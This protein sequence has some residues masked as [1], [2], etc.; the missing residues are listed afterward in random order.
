[1][2]VGGLMAGVSFR[3]LI[4]QGMEYDKH[5]TLAGIATGAVLMMFSLWVVD[6]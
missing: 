4:P 5:Y 1:M 3:E 6:G 2:M